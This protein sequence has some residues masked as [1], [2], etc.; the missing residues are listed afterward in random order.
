MKLN[1]YIGVIA[2]ISLLLLGSCNSG[3]S[4]SKNFDDIIFLIENDPQSYLLK[5]DT[6]NMN[7]VTSPK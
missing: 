6:I 7:C 4:E 3:Y 5:L 2:C 1:H